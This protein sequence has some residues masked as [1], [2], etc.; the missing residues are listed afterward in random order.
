MSRKYYSEYAA[1]C[2]RLYLRVRDDDDLRRDS[3]RADWDAARKAMMDLPDRTYLILC[4]V[5]T[6]KGNAKNIVPEVGQKYCAQ[7]NEIWKMMDQVEFRV[8]QYRGLR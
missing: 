7:T 6:S 4:D 8:A 2:I 1:H 5:Y 3:D